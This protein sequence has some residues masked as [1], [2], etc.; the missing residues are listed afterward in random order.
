MRSCLGS[1]CQFTLRIR[2]LARREVR[3]VTQGWE[4]FAPALCRVEKAV[5]VLRT[6]FD[7]LGVPTEAWWSLGR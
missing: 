3:Y 1:S 5:L 6:C 7:V 2:E 4:C